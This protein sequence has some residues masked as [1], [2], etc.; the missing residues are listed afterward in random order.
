MRS[1]L[2]P[3]GRPAC[4]RPTEPPVRIREPTADLGSERPSVRTLG[5]LPQ[6][7]D[8]LPELRQL[9]IQLS[10]QGEERIGVVPKSIGVRGP[11]QLPAEKPPSFVPL[12]Q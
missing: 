7:R 11:L 6:G 5:T 4:V 10:D 12:D 2:R 1:T 3:A 8:L 9:G